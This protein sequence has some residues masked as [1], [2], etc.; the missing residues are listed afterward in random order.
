MLEFYGS[1]GY[2][3]TAAFFRPTYECSY[4]L[5]QPANFNA[6]VDFGS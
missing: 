1:K 5:I 6:V 3:E 4:V 2:D